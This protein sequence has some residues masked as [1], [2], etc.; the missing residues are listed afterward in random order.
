MKKVRK[1]ENGGATGFTPPQEHYNFKDPTEVIY[2][3]K[4]INRKIKARE[5]DFRSK[6]P[7]GASGLGAD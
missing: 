4:N 3:K 1:N 2:L 5:N 6:S 7:S